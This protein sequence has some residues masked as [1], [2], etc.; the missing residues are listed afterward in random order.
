M[1]LT[2]FVSLS[3]PPS[4]SLSILLSLSV[5]LSLSLWLFSLSLSLCVCVSVSL[6]LLSF[7]LPCVSLSLPSLS[8]VLSHT[9]VLS[10]SL[11]IALSLCVTFSLSLMHARMH[12]HTHTRDTYNIICIDVQVKK[13]YN[14]CTICHYLVSD[15]TCRH[16]CT[17]CHLS[18][19][20]CRSDKTCGNKAVSVTPPHPSWSWALLLVVLWLCESQTC[21]V[22]ANHETGGCCFLS[23]PLHCRN[24]T[25]ICAT[26]LLVHQ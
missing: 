22:L 17:F 16:R 23:P 4:L 11:S 14:A 1:C 26:I 25:I 15:K 18:D 13:R 2:C 12:P 5:P 19:K 21:A 10:V 3:L 24:L 7:V 8:L 6:L 9:F 20:T